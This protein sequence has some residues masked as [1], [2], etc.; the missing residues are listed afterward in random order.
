[1][2]MRIFG[3][4]IGL[5]P[6]PVLLRFTPKKLESSELSVVPSVIMR[7][8]NIANRLYNIFYE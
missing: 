3:L 1:M 4:G 6:V 5:K 7:F 2:P 8:A